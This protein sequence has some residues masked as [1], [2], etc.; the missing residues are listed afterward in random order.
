ML[1]VWYQ[2]RWILWA[3][4]DVFSWTDERRA[5]IKPLPTSLDGAL[6][7]L[8]EDHDFLMAGDVFNEGLIENW[9]EY[10]RE[11]E[12]YPVHN[13]PHPYEMNLYFDV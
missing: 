10:K 5:A 1:G 3:T 13:R 4:S 8:S 11:M 2:V 12:Y 7:A 6:S 9:I